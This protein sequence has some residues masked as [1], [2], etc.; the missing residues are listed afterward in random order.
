MTMEMIGIDLDP[1]KIISQQVVP[2]GKACVPSSF[3]NALRF[4]PPSFQ[5]TFMALPGAS[6]AEKLRSLMEVR[7]SA[8]SEVQRGR[9]LFEG[10]VQMDDIAT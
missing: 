4:G 3:L 1:A 7:G 8:P 10:G 6:E 5:K 9:R 2:G